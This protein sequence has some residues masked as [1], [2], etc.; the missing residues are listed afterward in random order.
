MCLFSTNQN[1][2]SVPSSSL[3]IDVSLSD[4]CPVSF[5]AAALK[6]Y[7]E[8]LTS[9]PTAVRDHLCDPGQVT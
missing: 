6:Y 7:S 1:K 5:V 8:V 3:W 4:V 9:V 2:S